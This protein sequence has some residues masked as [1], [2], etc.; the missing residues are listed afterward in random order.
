MNNDLAKR[1]KKRI[2]RAMRVRKRL[3]GSSV[4]PRMS[5]YKTNRHISVQII[6]DEKGITL[7]SAGTLNKEFQKG[8]FGKKSK[9]AAKK[10]GAKIAQLAKGKDIQRVIFDRGRLK[11]HGVIAELADA[12]RE[13][14]LQF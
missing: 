10:I 13:A 8:E 2:K 5:V 6:D 12:A 3:R 1:T 9:E 14:G 7:A 11:Y 4:S